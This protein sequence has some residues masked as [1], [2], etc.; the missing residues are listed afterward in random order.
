M[1]TVRNGFTY[2]YANVKVY[3]DLLSG[4]FHDYNTSE[5]LFHK[6]KVVLICIGKNLYSVINTAKIQLYVVFNYLKGQ[7]HEKSC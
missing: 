5:P 4:Y 2:V 3:R 6:L 7:C 1:A